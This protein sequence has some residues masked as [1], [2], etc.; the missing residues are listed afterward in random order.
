MTLP[1]SSSPAPPDHGT[2]QE[3]FDY[4]ARE[5]LNERTQQRLR[6]AQEVV[7]RV[8]AAT[9]PSLECLNVADI[10]CGAGS[11]SILWAKSGHRV[12]GLDVNEPLVNLAR[13]RAQQDGLD[14]EF[15]VGTAVDL[16]WDDQ[17]MD[18]CLAPELLEHVADWESCVNEFCRILRPNGVLYLSTSNKLCPQQQEFTLP[19]YSWYPGPLKRYCERLATTTHPQIA[20][21]AK[22]PAVNWFSFYQLRRELYERGLHARDRFDLIDTD[23]KSGLARG[24]IRLVRALPPL[25]LLG[26]MATPYTIVVAVKGVTA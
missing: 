16:P 15:K 10:G 26:H 5:S 3:F 9:R 22:Y 21:H 14:I 18:V 4:Y 6:G 11:S 20:G 19:L 8:L 12:H 1:P 2:R 24:V 17:S 25:R 23:A 13:E 7:V